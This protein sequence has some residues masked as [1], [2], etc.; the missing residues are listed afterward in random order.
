ML[1]REGWEKSGA[2]F[3]WINTGV[4][5]CFSSKLVN[6]RL[7]FGVSRHAQNST[8]LELVGEF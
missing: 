8:V 4:R 2:Q 1:L 5:V 7:E 6:G 3:G